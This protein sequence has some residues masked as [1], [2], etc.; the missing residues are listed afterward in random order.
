MND[1]AT[2]PLV[3]ALD[4]GRSYPIVF[5]RIEALPEALAGVGLRAARCLVVTDENVHACHGARLE[6]A[7]ARGGAEA[8]TLVLP[9]GEQT[10]SPEHLQRLYD[11]ALGWPIDRKTV[12]VALGGGVVG[13]L[14]GFAA[15]T[16]LR[17]LPLAQIPTS[18][19]AQ[20]DSAV[21]GKTGI[22][23][24]AG[25]NLIGAFYQPALVLS[26]ASTLGTL[27]RRE[28]TGGLAEVVKHGLIADAALFDFL[29]AHW[30]AV[31]RAEPALLPRLVRDA[32]AVK[33]AVV[34]QDER[35]HGLRAVLNFGHTFGHAVERV[36]GYGRF[37]HGEAVALGMRAALHLSARRRPGFPLERALGLVGRIPTPPGARA[38]DEQALLGAMQVDKKNDAGTVRF[39]LLG[40][41]GDA[42]VAA[43]VA[44][45]EALDA[46]R[47]ACPD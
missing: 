43:D 45:E 29:E 17:G 8:R 22:N 36:A 6:A 28:W 41:I 26:D 27:P 1:P 37:T 40:G 19:V 9:P 15:A 11:A 30:E 34:A 7:L 20:V 25:K 23:H 10:K 18:L 35:E 42:Y 4:G 14:A 33:A 47:T 46:W 24:A 31:F 3:I 44:P 5:D 2:E 21:G 13:D 12:V 16:L 38:L 32:V 39:V